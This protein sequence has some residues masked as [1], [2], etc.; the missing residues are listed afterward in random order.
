[1]PMASPQDEELQS[2]GIQPHDE[3]MHPYPAEMPEW[4]ES[5]FY[6]WIDEQGSLA[7]HCRVGL[8]PAD[9]KIWL[10]LF[11]T[12][13]DGWVAIEKTHLPYS[14]FTEDIWAFNHE[15]LKFERGVPKPLRENTLKVSGMARGISGSH[16]DQDIPVDVS[17]SFHAAGAAYSMGEREEAGPDGKE[18]EAKRFEQPMMVQGTMQIGEATH[19]IQ[20]HGERDHSWGTRYWELMDWTFLILHSDKLRA[21]C[22]EVLFGENSFTLGYV[23]NPKMVPI[24]EA[25]FDMQFSAD[26]ENPCSGTIKIPLD[27][28]ETLEGKVVP[29]GVVPIEIAHVYPTPM[30]SV[31]RR[32]LVRWEPTDG[33][34]PCMGWL[35]WCRRP[36]EEVAD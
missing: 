10:W 30:D 33:S 31:Y 17:L 1:M 26:L 29:V 21:Q 2:F 4:Q 35:E 20:G 36:A 25:S 16:Q 12:D 14:E 34:E 3:G 28:G 7:G 9:N 23:Q 22:T 15:G 11:L 24:Y 6:D 18:Y 19:A 32:A 5:I 27:G 8:H 13:G